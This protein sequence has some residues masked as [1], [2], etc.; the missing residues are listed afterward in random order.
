MNAHQPLILSKHYI[1]FA[2]DYLKNVIMKYELQWILFYF[3]YK[4][5]LN[6]LLL[7]RKENKN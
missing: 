5:S 7:N 2:N 3:I 4:P 1:M 6:C